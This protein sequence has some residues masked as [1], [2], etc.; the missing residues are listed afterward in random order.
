MTPSNSATPEIRKLASAL[1]KALNKRQSAQA[2][3]SKVKSASEKRAK[4]N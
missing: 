2:T 4:I 1:V 3:T